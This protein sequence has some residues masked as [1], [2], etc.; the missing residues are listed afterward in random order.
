MPPSV[1]SADGAARLIALDWGTSAL[2]AYLLGDDAVVLDSR[3][4]PWGIM[5]LPEG[6]FGVAFRRVTQDWLARAPNAGVL[7]AGM[8]GS[9]QGWQEVPYCAAPAGVEELARSVARCEAGPLW[10]VPGVS[11]LGASPDVMRGEET[12]I[13]G[14]LA[15]DS[16]LAERSL[17]VLPGTHSKWVHVCDGRIREFTTYVTG[18]LFAVLSASSILGRLAR[19]A[20]RSPEPAQA[21]RAF[22]RG[23]LAARASTHGMAPLLFSARSLVLAGRLEPESSLEYLSGRLIGEELRCGLADG[24]RPRALIGDAAL[25]ARYGA[26]L[27]LFDIDPAP[28][29]EQTAAAGLWAIAK[30]ARLIGPT[31]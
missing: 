25:C 10:I 14:A 8:V 18:E 23:V 5:Q 26:A 1:P 6:G 27:E 21:T 16:G 22:E 4:E 29:I 13:V 20:A 28:V 30:G 17:L 9:A 15:R 12:Q 19:D 7:A 11:Q 2:R 24:E 31:T 3:S